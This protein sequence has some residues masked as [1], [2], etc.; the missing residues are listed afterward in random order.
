MNLF[1]SLFGK[2]QNTVTVPPGHKVVVF[3]PVPNANFGR[4][5]SGVW[6]AD[7]GSASEFFDVVA[8]AEQILTSGRKHRFSGFYSRRFWSREQF[9][10]PS[11]LHSPEWYGSQKALLAIARSYLMRRRS[12]YC[13]C[14][15][16]GTLELRCILLTMVPASWKSTDPTGLWLVCRE[17]HSLSDF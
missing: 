14:G 17:N 6:V 11:S 9:S 12:I 7:L 1:N 3:H 13:R 10:I 4:S 16:S 8:R 15:S 2:K 5:E